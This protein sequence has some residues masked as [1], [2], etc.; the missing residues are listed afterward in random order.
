[1]SGG[2]HGRHGGPRDQEVAEDVGGQQ[3][4]EAV[5]FL[6]GQVQDARKELEAK[7]EALRRYKE[8]RMGKLPEQLEFVDALPRNPTGKIL[9]RELQAQFADESQR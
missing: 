4:E 1:M 8:E 7:D 3:V 6:V 5:D 2:E 9:K